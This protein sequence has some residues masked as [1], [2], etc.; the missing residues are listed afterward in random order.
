MKKQ[1]TAIVLSAV[2]AL[3]TTGI[4]AFAAD[5]EGTAVPISAKESLLVTTALNDVDEALAFGII[6]SKDYDFEKDVTREQFCEFAYN[7]VNSVKELPM[8]K[9][10]RAPFDDVSNPK[11]NALEFVGI[12]K[13]TGEY[14]FSPNDT[15]TREEAAVIFNRIAEYTELEMPMVKVDMSYA[16]NSEISPWAVRRFIS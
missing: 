7:M 5:N 14:T 11:I 8:A 2:L 4:S 10:S 6:D 3:G 15:I 1:T 12:V 9:L 13:G 16:D